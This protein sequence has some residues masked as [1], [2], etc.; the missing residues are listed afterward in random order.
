MELT[1]ETLP[2]QPNV[3]LYRKG[4]RFVMVTD[5]QAHQERKPGETKDEAKDRIARRRLG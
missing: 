4:R 2:N 3:T 5:W 1:K